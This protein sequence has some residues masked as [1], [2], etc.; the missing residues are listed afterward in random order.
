M[1]FEQYYAMRP[2][3]QPEV[4]TFAQIVGHLANYNYNYMECSDARGEKNPN[5]G[6]DFEKL[7]TKAD[8]VAALQAA[9]SYCAL[10]PTPPSPTPRPARRSPAT[11]RTG[12]KAQ[13][14]AYRSTHLQPRAQ[15]RTLR[16]PHHLYAHQGNRSPIVRTC[17]PDHKPART[18]N[19][20]IKIFPHL[21]R[22]SLTA[23][24]LFV[25]APVHEVVHPFAIQ[26]PQAHRGR[27]RDPHLA[28]VQG[29]SHRSRAPRG[30]Q[31]APRARLHL[32]SQDP[33]DH[34]R[35]RPRPAQRGRQS[36]H[37][38]KRHRVTC[39][40]T[41][42]ASSSATSPSGSSAALPP[43]SP[44]TRSPCSPPAP[45][46]CRRSENLL[47]VR[48][49]REV[50]RFHPSCSSHH[51]ESPRLDSSSTCLAGRP[52]PSPSPTSCLTS[53]LA[54]GTRKATSQDALPLR[55]RCPCSA[56]F[57]AAAGTMLYEE[58]R[59]PP[60][61]VHKSWPRQIPP[62]PTP[63]SLPSSTLPSRAALGPLQPCAPTSSPP[64][65]VPKPSCPGSTASGCSES[66]RSPSAPSAAG[67]SFNASALP[68][69]SRSR[70]ISPPA[71]PVSP[72][73]SECTAAS[74]CASPTASPARSPSAV[75]RSLILLLCIRAH[76]S[77]RRSAR[78]RPRPR[79]RP[80]I[81]LRADYLWN[82]L[83]TMIETLFFFHP[84]CLVGRL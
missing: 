43:S 72:A 34:D 33:P 40:R 48:T 74:R 14:P 60:A 61:R 1:L 41:R 20:A 66:S 22:F 28:L 82:I 73:A 9:L 4:R 53:G 36:S 62:Q 54:R 32:R 71:S 11:S 77:L 49:P 15:Q 70:P 25:Y 76:H 63:I 23:T 69:S 78:S 5:A 67:W 45:A 26:S 29:R 16:K 57:A 18:K 27:A 10:Q 24:N 37:L 83:Q 50:M 12:G 68:P 51:L 65:L 31:P 56:C 44:C 19:R 46:N 47:S 42:R 84:C 39:R 52:P 30:R 38:L 7:T 35:K 8:L 79:A 2:G 13:A 3:T 17:R 59:P 81:S 55:S 64:S 21:R 80:A 6:N 58:F 75:V